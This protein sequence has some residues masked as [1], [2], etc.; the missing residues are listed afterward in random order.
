MKDSGLAYT[1]FDFIKTD[2]FTLINSHLT[3]V[4]LYIHYKTTLHEKSIF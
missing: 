1:M 3:I 4:H 2:Y